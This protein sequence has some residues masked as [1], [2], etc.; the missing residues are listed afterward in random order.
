MLGLGCL[1]AV[2][3]RV[4]IV[5]LLGDPGFQGLIAFV[6]VHAQSFCRASDEDHRFG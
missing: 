5:L 4:A 3:G 1:Q 6:H 2:P